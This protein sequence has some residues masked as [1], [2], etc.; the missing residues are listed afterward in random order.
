[1]KNTFDYKQESLDALEEMDEEIGKELLNWCK[2]SFKPIK[3]INK[4][5][6]FCCKVKKY[7]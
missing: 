6:W 7:S 2:K 1:M 5:C 4:K 3:S